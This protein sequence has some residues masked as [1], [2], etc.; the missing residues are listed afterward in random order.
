MINYQKKIIEI[1]DHWALI[2]INII[3][4]KIPSDGKKRGEKL[5]IY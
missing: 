3:L 1:Q 4:W 2:K 5:Q